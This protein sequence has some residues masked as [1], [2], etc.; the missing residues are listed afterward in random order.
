MF[1]AVATILQRTAA[2]IVGKSLMFL[3]RLW[4]PKTSSGDDL[5][6]GR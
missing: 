1:V 3:F 5:D 6:I 4:V 2:S